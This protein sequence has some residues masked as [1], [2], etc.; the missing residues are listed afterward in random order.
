MRAALPFALLVMSLGGCIDVGTKPGDVVDSRPAPD[1]MPDAPPP[2]MCK[3]RQQTAAN[4]NHNAGLDCMA[5][6]CHGP[7]GSAPRFTLAGTLYAGPT[8]IAIVKG[9]VITIQ[10]ANGVKLDLISAA[11]GNFY[12][13]QQLALP[14]T[15]YASECPA[16]QPMVSSVT[17]TSCN[18][19]HYTGGQQPQI[20]LP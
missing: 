5:G 1:A 11:N 4:G 18:A 17:D 14:V 13:S 2:P 8:G 19:C 6:N 15:V 7:A 20:H 10:D 3:D 16:L 12:T 9:G